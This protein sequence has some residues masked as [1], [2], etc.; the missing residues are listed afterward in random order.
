MV[1]TNGWTILSMRTCEAT[2]SVLQER[3]GSEDHMLVDQFEDH[4]AYDYDS[5]LILRHAEASVRR[6]PPVAAPAISHVD[7]A[8]FRE[9]MARLAGG[10]A[11]V[12]CWDGDT[13][14]GLLIS[15]LIALSTEPPRVLF[16]VRKEASSHAAMSTAASCSITILSE[17]DQ[18]EAERFSATSRTG[19]RFSEAHWSLSQDAP[20]TYRNALVTLSG[21]ITQR[22]DT[23]TH[24]VLILTVTTSVQRAAAPLVYY[25]RAFRGLRD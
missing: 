16:C 7:A 9:A 24:T 14:K 20:P 11:I 15:S 21:E 10:V 13:P 19:E 2:V 22:H 12:S 1:F 4:S 5:G 3:G 6:T 8:A 25:D 17:D 18:E 23:G